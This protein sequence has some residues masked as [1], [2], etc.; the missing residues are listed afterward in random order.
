MDTTTEPK[1][2]LRDILVDAAENLAFARKP[3]FFNI[4]LVLVRKKKHFLKKQ[5]LR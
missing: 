2:T 3:S 1:C 4:V 5:I